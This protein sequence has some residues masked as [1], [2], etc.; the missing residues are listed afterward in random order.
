MDR[1]Y[2]FRRLNEADYAHYSKFNQAGTWSNK[3]TSD[4]SS[5]LSARFTTGDWQQ[6][7]EFV[8]I[9]T[10]LVEIQSKG[11]PS[12]SRRNEETQNESTDLLEIQSEK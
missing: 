1:P 7:P 2:L 3:E 8:P 6:T 5:R 10:T 12:G 9:E 11:W 4:D